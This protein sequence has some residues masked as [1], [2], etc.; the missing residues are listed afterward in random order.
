MPRP[1]I[2]AATIQ[3]VAAM[4]RYEI[5]EDRA[6]ALAPAYQRVLESLDSLDTVELG[7]TPPAAAFDPRWEQ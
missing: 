4:A 7:E 5:E 2:D 3:R 1:P 6:V